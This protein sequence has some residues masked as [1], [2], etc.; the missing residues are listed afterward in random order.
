VLGYFIGIYVDRA[1]RGLP[2]SPA[3]AAWQGGLQLV[4]T[5]VATALSP[6]SSQPGT[7]EFFYV[8]AFSAAQAALSGF[9]SGLLF[10]YFYRRTD[11]SNT[12][13]TVGPAS[14]VP[15]SV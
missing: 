9:L 14:T 6:N 12:R 2:T 11:R 3:V 10:Q 1:L 13:E 7:R 5:S 4:A 15:V 8:V